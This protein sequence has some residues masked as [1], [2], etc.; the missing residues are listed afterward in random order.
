MSRLLL[1]AAFASYV[2]GHGHISNIIVNGVS[3]QGWDIS[4]FPY[5]EDVPLVA[6]WGTPNTGGGFPT[7]GYSAPDIICHLNA[8]N[9]EGSIPVAAGDSINLQWTEWPETHHGPVLDYLANCGSSCQTV[10][11]TTLEFFKISEV[12]LVD[13]SS[14]PGLWG[15]DDLIENNSAWLV[16]IPE[17]IAPGNYVLRHELIALQ[18]AHTENGAQNYMQC[19]NLQITGSGSTQPDG[20][21]GTELYTS[22]DPGILVDIFKSLTY[23]IPGPSLIPG[24]TAVAQSTSAITSTGTAIVPSAT[25]S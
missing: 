20:V 15:T 25:V 21:L 16:Q 2:V 24:A 18:G 22:T 23:T 7:D 17:D 12:G 9:G 3:Y 11:K 1:V 13:D 14:V 6:A 19:I 5:M 10:D 4:S 8:T